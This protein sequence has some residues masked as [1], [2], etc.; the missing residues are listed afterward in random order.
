MTDGQEGTVK[1]IVMITDGG[2]GTL[3]P[4]NLAN[5]TTLTFDDIGDSASMIFSAGSWHF[6]GGTATLA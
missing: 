2:A 3:T 4:L 6:M 5:G 1:Y